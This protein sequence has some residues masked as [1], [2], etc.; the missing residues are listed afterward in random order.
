MRG[1][2]NDGGE[3]DAV[4]VRITFGKKCCKT[5]V[6]GLNKGVY[7]GYCGCQGRGSLTLLR[8]AG[9]EAEEEVLLVTTLSSQ[10]K[11]EICESHQSPCPWSFISKSSTKG[12]FPLDL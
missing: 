5:T 6:Q 3:S 1:L 12:Y 4:N 7:S 11:Y 2:G 8:E 9:R 10:K